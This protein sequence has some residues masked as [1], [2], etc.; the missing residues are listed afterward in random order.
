M[1]RLN[2]AYILCISVD[3][4]KPKVVF[5]PDKVF[6]VS[7]TDSPVWVNITRPVFTD[8][9]GIDKYIPPLIDGK[10]F[11]RFHGHTLNFEAIDANGNR[12]KCTF[13]VYV[14]GKINREYIVFLFGSRYNDLFCGNYEIV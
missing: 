5:C 13:R 8:N 9:V 6:K 2:T 12:A 3:N 11:T 10:Y 7:F 1:N 4:E 14:G